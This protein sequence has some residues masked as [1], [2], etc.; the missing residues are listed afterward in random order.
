MARAWAGVDGS[1]ALDLYAGWRDA[2]IANCTVH[3]CRDKEE[4]GGIWIRDQFNMGASNVVLSGNDVR[5]A[6]HDEIVAVSEAAEAAIESATE[7]Y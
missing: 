7:S 4:G 6:C 2:T 3:V 5:K 1:A